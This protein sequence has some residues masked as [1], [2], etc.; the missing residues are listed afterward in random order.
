MLPKRCFL[1]TDKGYREISMEEFQKNDYTGKKFLCLHAM[2]M[3]VKEEDYKTFYKEREHIRYLKA[4]DKKHGLL[5]YHALDAEGFSGENIL[6]DYEA[7][8]A[9]IDQKFMIKDLLQKVQ[10]CLRKNCI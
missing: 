7:D 4:L 10:A 5:S 8:M 3:E 1:L 2:L 9:N 6:V